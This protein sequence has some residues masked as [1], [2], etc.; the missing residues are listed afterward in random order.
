VN[1]DHV[2]RKIKR[3]VKDINEALE[4]INA[5]DSITSVI[6]KCENDPEIKSKIPLDNQYDILRM[7]RQVQY[8]LANIRDYFQDFKEDYTNLK[9]HI[10]FLN[11]DL[12]RYDP[13]DEKKD[14]RLTRI[15]KRT[16]QRE[17][18]KSKE[19]HKSPHAKEVDE[20][21]EI[22]TRHLIDD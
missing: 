4:M 20:Y 6:E 3:F 17:A 1:T 11:N 15:V 12:K 2:D 10:D 13:S 22:S 5:C 16:L 7:F 8:T 9:N 14:R 18:F 19:W 21:I